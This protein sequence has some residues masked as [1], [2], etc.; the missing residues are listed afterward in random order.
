VDTIKAKID[1]NTRTDELLQAQAAEQEAA[2]TLRV[3][4][5]LSFQK[6]VR[7][8]DLNA[9]APQPVDLDRYSEEQVQQL[10]ELASVSADERTAEAEVRAA[11]AERR[12]SLSYTVTAG[13]DDSRIAPA[14]DLGASANLSL[15]VPVF[16]W[17]AARSR[18][19]QAEIRR[20]T[21]QLSRR[22]TERELLQ[23][24]YT[25]RGQVN[26][27]AE[28]ARLSAL[29]VDEAQRS[30]DISIARYKAGEAP[31]LE[32][33]EARAS[34]AAERNALEQALYDYHVALGHLEQAV[35]R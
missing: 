3:L 14:D 23:K 28:R 33:S 7:V 9:E 31:V 4:L 8:Q 17:G 35:G 18:Q 15:E 22:I 12:P 30:L 21:A 5:G 6:P 2:D 25:A 13:I 10:P 32:V 26:L 24:F 20:Q 34:L 29:A 1:V 16:D 19:R 27:A 11:R